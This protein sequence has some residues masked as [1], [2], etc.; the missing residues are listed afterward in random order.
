MQL[1]DLVPFLASENKNVLFLDVCTLL[2]VVRGPARDNMSVVEA[3]VDMD[4]QIQTASLS[5][6][7]V[8]PS[9]FQ[10]E[11]D[12][13]ISTVREELFKAMERHQKLSQASDRLHM[14]LLGTRLSLPDLRTHQFE[15]KLEQMCLRIIRSA[16]SINEYDDFDIRAMR[17]VVDC[18]APASKG[19]QEAKD[20]KIFEETL[21]VGHRLRGQGFTK[22]IVFASSNT[23]DYMAA[24]KPLPEIKSDLDAIGAEFTSSLNHAYHI[25]NSS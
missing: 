2:D 6:T 25:A 23:T 24:G 19:K 5:F 16:Q 8:L 18:R 22:K 10:K 20:C 17:R 9:L 1:D 14:L 3:A 7:I 15:D 4:V 12:D 21:G 11:W 13:N